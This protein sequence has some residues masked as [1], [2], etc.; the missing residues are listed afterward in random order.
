MLQDE[1]WGEVKRGGGGKGE[2]NDNINKV[3]VTEREYAVEVLPDNGD[4]Y[5][6]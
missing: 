2:G 6:Y 3:N 4:S 1:C 5:F